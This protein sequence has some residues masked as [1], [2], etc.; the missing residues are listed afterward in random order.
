MLSVGTI[1]FEDRFYASKKGGIGGDGWVS[2]RGARHMAA[3]LGGCRKALVGTDCTMS[4][5][6]DTNG[7]EYKG[8]SVDRFSRETRAL[9]REP[10]TLQAC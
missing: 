3:A 5:L 9:V 2:V 6:F 7:R 1:R 8:S 4:L 10:W